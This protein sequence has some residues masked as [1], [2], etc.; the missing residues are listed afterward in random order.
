[1]DRAIAIP[2]A[3]DLFMSQVGFPRSRITNNSRKD[4]YRRIVRI[5]KVS[6]HQI[7]DEPAGAN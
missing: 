4:S 2:A 3:T 7:L 6:C 5:Y 1:M